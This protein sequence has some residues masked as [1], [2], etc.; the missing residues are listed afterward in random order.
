MNDKIDDLKNNIINKFHKLN[1]NWVKNRDNYDLK[2]L[3][4]LDDC[5]PTG[6]LINLIENIISVSTTLG[7]VDKIL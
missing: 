7:L 2:I 4:E 1:G 5:F 3:D 6:R